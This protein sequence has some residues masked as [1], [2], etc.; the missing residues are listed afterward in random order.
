MRGVAYVNVPT[1]LLAQHDAA[2]GGKVA[3]NTAFA[4]NF[5]G[6]FHHPRAVFADP[7]TLATLD[8]RHIAAGIAEAIKVALC[9]NEALFC[10]L[11]EG[12]LAIRQ[13]R[14][15]R[16]LGE[17]VRRATR[18]KIE[19]LAPDP[20]EH[21]LRRALNLGHS[22]GHPLET[23]LAYTGILHGEAVGFGLAVAVEVARARRVCPDEAA[24][25][26]LALLA[27]YGL[28]PRVPRGRLL[29]A[30]ARMA[31]V[32]LVR[33]RALHYVLPVGVARVEIV[34]QVGDDE[35]RAALDA[36]AWHPRLGRCVVEEDAAE[37]IAC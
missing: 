31:E 12:V 7:A 6:A 9:G 33:G 26:I 22:F 3:V 34:P 18:K 21:D 24:E 8:E 27:D 36:I 25:R 30:C 29:A 37:Q 1:T 28:P 11:E 17:V 4:K 14:D 5:V 23:E 19:L 2:V 16:V 20:Y 10:L 32:R 13:W 35:I 15:A